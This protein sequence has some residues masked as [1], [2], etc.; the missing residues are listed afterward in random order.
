MGRKSSSSK[1][2]V[3]G[4]IFVFAF[5]EIVS[6]CSRTYK[7]QDHLFLVARRKAWIR[8]VSIKSYG[9]SGHWIFI[10]ERSCYEIKR[11]FLRNSQDIF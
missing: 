9:Y 4:Y 6:S 5:L 2:L 8:N 3:R 10:P 7:I 1:Q 11:L